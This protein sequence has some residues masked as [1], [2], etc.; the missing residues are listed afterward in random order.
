MKKILI[1]AVIIFL[2]VGAYFFRLQILQRL[3][4]L[5]KLQNLSENLQ[6]SQAVS[7]LKKHILTAQPLRGLQDSPAAYLTRA[8]TIAQTNISRAQNNRAALK[9]NSMLD[10]AAALK[11]K[12]MFSGQYFEHISPSGKGPGDLAS[13]V[14]YQY[15]DI[16]ENLALGNFEND[17]ALVEAWMNSP[18]HRANILNAQFT[19]IG[20]AVGQGMFDGKQ[21]WLAV[22]EFGKP[23]SSCPAVDAALKQEITGEQ[24]EVDILLAQLKQQKADLDA[25]NPQTRQDY[26]QYNRQVAALN[27]LIRI[28]NNKVDVLKQN[29]ANYNAQV[30]NFNACAAE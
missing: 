14:N 10:A 3:R 30:Q 7:D 24:G 12:D 21:T 1:L 25:Q 4:P 8:G 26:E 17:Q 23:A 16:G 11:L 20:V 18:G 9:E 27:D 13:E 19:E 2:A 15:I 29:V 22:Q 6:Q 28:Y 5:Q